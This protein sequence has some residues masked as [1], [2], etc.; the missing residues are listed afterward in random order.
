MGRYK[1]VV[2]TN[3]IEGQDRE[4]NEWYDNQHLADVVDVP[5]FKSAQRFRLR[6]PM[7][8]H[9]AQRHLAIYEIETD[10]PDAA[11]A[12]LQGRRGTDVMR[13]SDALDLD[14]SVAGLFEACSPVVTTT[15]G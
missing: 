3:P 6:D 9:H 5:G 14:T 7:G 13:L 2:L 1:L 12:A 4:Y 10:D 8:Y 15:N 11:I